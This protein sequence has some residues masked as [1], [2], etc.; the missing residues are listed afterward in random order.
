VIHLLFD[1]LKKN[2][3]RM[4]FE[5]DLYPCVAVAVSGGSDS[6]ALLV[7]AWQ[8]AQLRGATIVALT[9]DHCMRSDSLSDCLFVKDLSNK[10]GI[11]CHILTWEHTS[12]I[13]SNLQAQARRARYSLMADFC[14]QLDILYLCVGH[15]EDDV[16]ENF[17]L[18]L[19]R[20]ATVFGLS[21]QEVTFVDDIIVLRP[22]LSSRKEECREFLKNHAIA[23]K[24]DPSNHNHKFTRNKVRFQLNAIVNQEGIIATQSHLANLA[25]TVLREYI[26][27]SLFNYVFISELGYVSIDSRLFEEVHD[28]MQHII[29]AH[30]LTIVRGSDKTPSLKSVKLIWNKIKSLEIHS[31]TLHGCLIVPRGDR[32][33]VIR[34]FGKENVPV[35]RLTDGALWDKRFRV[36]LLS[37]DER[38]SGYCFVDKL[39]PW[40]F[41][42]LDLSFRESSF[43]AQVEFADDDLLYAKFLESLPVV[44][45]ERGDVVCVPHAF[46]G[47]KVTIEGNLLELNFRPSFI[48]HFVHFV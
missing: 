19:M 2:L 31:C 4:I 12:V 34:A 24:E 37:F 21:M 32:I 14:K 26:I 43:S 38:F 39:S 48:S 22:M 13:A 29:V 23:W 36:N 10:Y 46:D 16:V 28:E 44:K 6:V 18:R 9:V 20:S 47:N 8:W 3:D 11:K 7:L 17:F 33:F 15:H 40:N 1:R 42:S 45:N 25:Q 30:L 5:R 27:A 35:A 41:G